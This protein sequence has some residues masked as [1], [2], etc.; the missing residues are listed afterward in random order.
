MNSKNSSSGGMGLL[1]V[2]QTIFI[3]LK[4]LGLVSWTWAQVLIPTFIS[5][6]LTAIAII[7]IIVVL[8][9]DQI[10]YHSNDRFY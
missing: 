8:V 7:V 3:V 9:I 1:G 6:G 2:L 10:K 5:I 4:C